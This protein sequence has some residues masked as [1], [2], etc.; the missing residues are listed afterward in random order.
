MVW[1]LL[2][3]E[4][5][6]HVRHRCLR[7]NLVMKILVLY[8]VLGQNGLIVQPLAEEA[9]NVDRENVNLMPDYSAR[10]NRKKKDRAMKMSAQFGQI[11]VN[12]RN[13]LPL[14]EEEKPIDK[15]S[16]FCLK[17]VKK[18]TNLN[19]RM[20]TANKKRF[21]MM[22]SNAPNWVLGQIGPNAA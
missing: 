13:V 4:M 16:A 10:E 20:E 17:R 3:M 1:E 22:R 12:G 8:S 2:E 15:D 9:D 18:S 11:G 19:A 7:R 6:I 14:A 21:A 5:T